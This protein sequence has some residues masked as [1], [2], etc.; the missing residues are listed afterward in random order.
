MA[1]VVF[2]KH[3]LDTHV[4]I[5]ATLTLTT[6]T[7]SSID[8]NIIWEADKGT[9]WETVGKGKAFVRKEAKESHAGNYRCI[10]NGISSRV[11]KVS[12]G[13]VTSPEIESLEGVDATSFKA[14]KD[15][16]VFIEILEGTGEDASPELIEKVSKAVREELPEDLKE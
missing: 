4:E 9:G 8:P 5:G 14:T 11:A 3:P 7:L 15:N 13:E 12:V 10:I 6:K 1:K 16:D 2:R